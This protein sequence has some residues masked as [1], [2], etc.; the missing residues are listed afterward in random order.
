MTARQYQVLTA[1]GRDRPGLVEKISALL[2]VA[3]ANLEDSRMA[4]LGGEFAL[5]L[6]FS[7][8][9]TAVAAVA[10]QSEVLGRQLD[11]RISL[12]PTEPR[13]ARGEF[14]PYSLEVGG[15]DRPRR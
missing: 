8:P 2:L 10:Q 3:G 12:A 15:V 7:G 1:V 9:D 14:L 13:T 6:L 5:I 11:L 4:I